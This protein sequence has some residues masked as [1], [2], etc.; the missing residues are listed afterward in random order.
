MTDKDQTKEKL[1]LVCG[2]QI[3]SQTNRC[4]ERSA[5][6]Y[7]L[8]QLRPSNPDSELSHACNQQEQELSLVTADEW[9]DFHQHMSITHFSLKVQEGAFKFF[10]WSS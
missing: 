7:P 3:N 10:T 4:K 9:R 1:K 2:A 8:H 5:H 6:P